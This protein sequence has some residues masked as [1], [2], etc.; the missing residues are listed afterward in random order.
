MN[1][2]VEQIYSFQ[3]EQSNETHSKRAKK[4]KTIKWAEILR[5]EIHVIVL[6]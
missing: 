5:E 4:K 6:R 3:D 1:G 2:E